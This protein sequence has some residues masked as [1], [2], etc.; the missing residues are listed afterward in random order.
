MKPPYATSVIAVAIV[1]CALTSCTD[2]K[3]TCGGEDNQQ[4]IAFPTMTPAVFQQYLTEQ[5]AGLVNYS[6]KY[7][8]G[9]GTSTFSFIYKVGNVCPYED[10][11]ISTTVVL[12][13]PNP[14]I[15]VRL[16]VVELPDPS[17][18]FDQAVTPSN[19]VFSAS[20]YFSFLSTDEDNTQ[21]SVTHDISI[22]NFGNF[23]VDS[24]YFWSHVETIHTS[25]RFKRID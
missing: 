23:S 3:Q 21:Y 7:T 6:T 1:L 15:T 2:E 12:N 16:K 24:S 5:K 25:G 19:E 4:Y 8:A 11:F 13:T 14:N 9:S 10:A 18:A 17:N 20:E 22:P